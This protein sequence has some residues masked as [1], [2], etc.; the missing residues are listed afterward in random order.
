MTTTTSPSSSPV[1]IRWRCGTCNRQRDWPLRTIKQ[2]GDKHLMQ[3]NCCGGPTIHIGFKADET[4]PKRTRWNFNLAP[5]REV[6]SEGGR[7]GWR[8]IKLQ[9]SANP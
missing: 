9:G 3:C 8:K 7:K 5:S 1:K 2:A 6:L 4:P